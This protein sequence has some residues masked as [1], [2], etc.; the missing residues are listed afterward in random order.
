MKIYIRWDMNADSWMGTRT[1][2]SIHQTL[3]GAI[4]AV[5]EN[6]RTKMEL[7]ATDRYVKNYRYV[8]IEE[9]E[10]GA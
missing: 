1:L 7:P 10:I 6:I 4:A 3:E 5:P 8:A 9:R 2:L